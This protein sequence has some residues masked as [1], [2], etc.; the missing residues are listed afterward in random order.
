MVSKGDNPRWIEASEEIL[1]LLDRASRDGDVVFTRHGQPIGR[2]SAEP[3]HATDDELDEVI[4]GF[5]ELSSRCRLN[6]MSIKDM[7]NEGRKR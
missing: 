2:L 5:L 4:E 7:I 1:R 3:A 6:G